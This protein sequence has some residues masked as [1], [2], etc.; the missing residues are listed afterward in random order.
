MSRLLLHACCGVCALEPTR[1]LQEEHREFSIA[2]INPNIHPYEEYIKRQK[3]LEEYVCKA[4]NISYVIGRYDLNEWE[5]KVAKYALNKPK[6]CR[7]CYRLRFEKLAQHAQENGFDAISTTLTISPYQ[8]LEQIREELEHAA[9]QFGLK[10][11]FKDY[12]SLYREATRISKLNGM[13][14]QR[15]CGCRF[16]KLEA[17]VQQQKAKTLHLRK[18]RIKEY[19]LLHASAEGCVNQMSDL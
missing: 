10:A 5:E 8:Y 11:E 12:S 13:Y 6:R 9:K 1:I 3:A 19:A 4:R 17:Q 15:Y 18:K 16:S 2:Y 7:A 14:R